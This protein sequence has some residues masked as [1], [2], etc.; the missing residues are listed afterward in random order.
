MI[1]IN[2]NMDHLQE[3]L[4]L[5][6]KEYRQLQKENSRLQKDIAVLQSEQQ[7]KTEQLIQLEQKV[8]AVQLTG[9]NRD[10][11]EKA[12]LQK[13]IDTYLKEIDKCLALLHA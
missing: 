1:D 4:Q 11:A 13:K 8:A 7:K 10:E 12:R 9:G 5:L 2:T 3:K 6:I